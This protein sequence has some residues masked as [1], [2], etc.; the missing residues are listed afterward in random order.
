VH[1]DLKPANVFV[2]ARGQAK[3]LDFGLAKLTHEV[4][5]ASA[6]ALPTEA[7]PELTSPGTALGT[8][9]YMSPEQVR[10]EAL[11]AR[12]DLFSFG[13]VLYEM[14]TRRQAFSGA[15]TGVV[16]EAILNRE[17][18]PVA[19]ANPSVPGEVV[20]I[21]G[22][23]LEKDR[24]LRYQTAAEIRG[25]LKR[26]KRDSSSSIGARDADPGAPSVMGSS[27]SIAS[28][29]SAARALPW[30]RRHVAVA[31]VAL[32]GLG[33]LAFVVW[34]RPPAAPRVTAIRQL[35]HDGTGKSSVHTDGTRVFYNGWTGAAG[36]LLQVPVTGGDSVPLES[37]LRRPL[38]FDIHARRN[39]LLLEENVRADTPDRLWALSTTGGNPRP[40]GEIEISDGSW[41]PDGQRIVYT[42]GKDVFMAR[43]DGSG[44][45][46]LL[47]A[48]GS[49][50][51]PRLSP[52]GQRLRYEVWD[53][54]SS[55]SLWE[56]GSDGGGAHP[57][58]P[59]W[60]AWFGRWTPDGRYYVF[61]VDREGEAALWAWREK[62]R[63][64]WRGAS[65]GPL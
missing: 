54:A 49:A 44:S 14:A 36:P 4:A 58:L 46:R 38:V 19:E 57:L 37:P 43:S 1:R 40:L 59:G 42:R 35:T 3:V 32:V 17:P 5:A 26:L 29:A 7:A 18:F 31:L 47:T 52:D 55:P 13:V 53:E 8:V 34:P 16:F 62:G 28:S 48:P 64:P 65:S 6:S 60:K 25:D 41:S 2:T 45:R 33:A 50:F 23:A 24:E 63:W 11:D 30:R 22:K 51:S 15:T 9:A 10:G 61:V 12:T 27:A 21:I 39:E 20:R 56:A